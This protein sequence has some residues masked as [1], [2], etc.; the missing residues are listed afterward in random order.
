MTTALMGEWKVLATVCLGACTQVG[1]TN[2][3]AHAPTGAQTVVGGFL[4]LTAL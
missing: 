1:A 4:S 3:S 2:G